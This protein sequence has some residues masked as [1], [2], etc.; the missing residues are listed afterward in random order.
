MKTHP[1]TGRKS[2]FLASH[3]FGV[4]GLSPLESEKLLDDLAKHACQ[5]PR[6]YTHNWKVGD[7]L[8]WDNRCFMHRARPYD[9]TEPRQMRGTRI[10]GE[11][12]SETGLPAG[13]A[14]EVLAAH[15]QRL[16]ENPQFQDAP[17]RLR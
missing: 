1:E 8:L 2:L 13:F 6:V 9:P 7:L 14:S 10:A 15:L 4:P 17:G 12:D 11:P 16:R 5:A 3:A